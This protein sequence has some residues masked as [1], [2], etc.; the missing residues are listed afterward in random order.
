MSTRKVA[1]LGAS[2]NRKKFSNKSVRAHLAEG[3]EVYP[4]NPAGGTIEEQTAYTSILK[5][6]DG[7]LFRV[8][9]YVSPKIGIDLLEN[10]AQRGC[11]ELWLNPGTASDELVAKAQ[12]LGLNVIQSCSIVAIGRSPS[13]FGDD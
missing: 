10:I 9:M 13:E 7:E 6:P 4:I 11:E 1:I 8:S 3:F 2:N 12:E 5:V